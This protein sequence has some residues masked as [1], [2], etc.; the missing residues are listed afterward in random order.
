MRFFSFFS[1]CTF[2]LLSALGASA[3][4]PEPTPT[5][6]P[7]PVASTFVVTSMADTDGTTC[8]TTCTLRQAIKAAN[9]NADLNNITFDEN[10]F[11]SSRQTIVVPNGDLPA[12]KSDVNII[13]PSTLGAGLT[14]SGSSGLALNMDQ[15]QVSLA[16]LTLSGYHAFYVNSAANVTATS[17]TFVGGGYGINTFG[18]LTLLNC[19]STADSDGYALYQFAGT[20]TLDSCTMED[21]SVSSKGTANLLNT[22]V[23]GRYSGSYVD[24]GHNL[25]GVSTTQA[26]LDPNGLQDNGGPSKTIALVYG[27]PAIDKGAT[28]LATDQRGIARPQGSAPD[29]GA[30]EGVSFAIPTATPLPT[31][32]PIP[33]ATPQPSNFVVT[34]TADTDGSTCGTTCTLRQALNAANTTTNLNNITFDESVFGSSRKTITL[35]T[36]NLPSINSNVN[37]TGPGTKGSG[38]ILLNPNVSSGYRALYVYGGKVSLTNLTFTGYD[39]LRVETTVNSVTAT[40]CTFIGSNLGVD[41][42]GTLAL[43][44]CTASSSSSSGFGLRNGTSNTSLD[45]CTI[46]G[47][48]R[49]YGNVKI[50]NTIVVGNFSDSVL[51]DN[52]HNLI[53][54]SATQAGLDPKGLQ[55]NG[56]PTNTI[57]LRNG[58]IAINAGSTT[59]A[60]DQRGVARPQGSAPDIG[61]FEG[62]GLIVATP[63]PVATVTPTPLPVISIDSPSIVE[64]NGGDSSNKSVLFTLTLDKPSTSEITVIVNTSQGTAKAGGDYESVGRFIITFSPGATRQYFTVPVFGD[65]LVEAD[66]QF[67]LDLR[68]PVGA[69]LGTTNGTA[70]IL[71]DDLPAISI[72]S[73]SVREGNDGTTILTFTLTTDKPS[74]YEVS[75]IVNTVQGTAKA[76]SDYRSVPRAVVTFPPV[77][78]RQT[79]A[80]QV[81]PDTLVE[82]NEQFRLD[83]RSPVNATIATP[84]GTGTILNDDSPPKSP[85]FADSAPTS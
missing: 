19:T 66:E 44:N 34:S 74:P 75:V 54:V 67:R 41:T 69:T 29:I 3:I 33:T 43:I 80:V 52:G 18:T 79:F 76:G 8:G 10:V 12:I 9:A 11:G 16:N 25:V 78:T 5:A 30:F 4:T 56:G 2:A 64:G 85:S 51:T 47:V 77:A 83:L 68:S 15:G 61:A 45:S 37:L 32:T 31:A 58:S 40:N 14:L 49:S 60:T 22:V 71:N 57:A 72:N 50:A 20:L 36:G 62:Q 17:C 28:T 65:T 13:G 55:D 7:K 27:S 21:V 59:L 24:N 48:D 46:V 42:N 38:V 70:T 63:T 23:V 26:G 84:S 6:T 39:G 73:P 35:S 1:T 82:P 53:G 81:F